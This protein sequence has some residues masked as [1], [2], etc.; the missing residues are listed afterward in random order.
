MMRI[1]GTRSGNLWIAVVAAGG[2]VAPARAQLPYS[3]S[4][5]ATQTSQHYKFLQAGFSL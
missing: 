3:D 4:A 1:M 2:L 5:P